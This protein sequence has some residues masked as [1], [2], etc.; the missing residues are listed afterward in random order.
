MKRLST[1]IA[2]AVATAAAFTILPAHASTINATILL[3]APVLGTT[4]TANTGS[5][6]TDPNTYCTP[7]DA[8]C[9]KGSFAK[10]QRC[11]YLADQAAGTT[12]SQDGT[13]GKFGYLVSVP[14]LATHFNLASPTN[15]N[16]FDISFYISLGSCDGQAQH[17]VVSTP[18]TGPVYTVDHAGAP[19]SY[20][21]TS[22]LTTQT[23]WSHFGNGPESG[24]IPI[25]HDADGNVLHTHYAVVTLFGGANAPFSLTFS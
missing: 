22:T 15:A 25:G 5:T 10:A 1:L 16:D 4:N 2:A 24:T 3:P 20:D 6:S 19:T 9:Q 21:T 14:S 11:A 8:G 13:T 23:S 18:V 7:M 17:R 12:A